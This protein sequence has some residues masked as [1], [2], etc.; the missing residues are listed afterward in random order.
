MEIGI[1][2]LPQSGKT[3]AF[4]ALGGESAR[5][6]AERAHHQDPVIAT[7]PVPDER[8]EKLASLAESKRAVHAMIGY[9]DLPGLPPDMIERQHG[10]PD[11]HLQ[12]LGRVEALLAVVR[13]FDDGTGL[14]IT[15]EA[16]RETI[17][18]ELVVTDLQRVENR[19]EKLERTIHRVSGRERE[20]G[21]VEL[22]ALKKV[23]V[24]LNEGRPARIVD[25]EDREEVILRGMA[26][27]SQKPIAWLLNVN[28]EADS[29]P[30]IEASKLGRNEILLQLDAEM[31]KEI[32]E[33]DEESRAEFMESYGIEEP[34]VRKVAEACYR[35]LGRITFFTANEKEAHAWSLAEGGTALDAAGTVHSDFASGFIRAEVV[36]WSDLVKAGSLAEARKQNLLRAEGKHYVV[37]DGDVIQFLFHK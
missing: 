12:Y 28:A 7:V 29:A 32:E 1:V 30:E 24:A 33:L 35:L 17:E 19:V 23:Q 10:L 4:L 13:A 11:T 8:V 2:G 37:Q 15:V 18:T 25:L 6:A 27:L 20:E 16:D 22:A 31:E 3:T 26:L 14:P 21:E 34:A 36:G 5:V 9:T